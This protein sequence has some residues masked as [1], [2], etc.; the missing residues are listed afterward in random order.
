MGGDIPKEFEMQ[1]MGYVIINGEKI[2]VL[3][4]NHNVHRG[5]KRRMTGKDGAHLEDEEFYLD[6]HPDVAVRL[7][8]GETVIL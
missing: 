4:R 3:F 8:Q 2:L 1:S 5:L 6:T 7:L